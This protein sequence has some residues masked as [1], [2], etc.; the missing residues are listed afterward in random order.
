[1]EI[2]WNSHP[3]MGRGVGVFGNS[4]SPLTVRKQME[5][6]TAE[7]RKWGRG[8]KR[9]R[10]PKKEGA[11]WGAA[12]SVAERQVRVTRS[13]PPALAYCLFLLQKREDVSYH[14]EQQR[15]EMGCRA[16]S[17]GRLPCQ[18]AEQLGAFP[19]E[20]EGQGARGS[21]RQGAY[22]SCSLRA[23]SK[24]VCSQIQR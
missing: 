19:R 3:N 16:K 6:K 22:D 13:M 14:P 9:T 5:P 21:E 18:I 17:E 1:M 4:A 15:S 8:L 2:V 11:L 24:N 10:W 23:S 12:A 7:G 20:T